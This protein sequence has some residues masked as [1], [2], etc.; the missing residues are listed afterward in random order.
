MI[1]THCHL[2]DL[3]ALCPYEQVL[4]R[5]QRAGVSSLISVGVAPARWPGQKSVALRARQEGF[6]VGLAY[7]IHPWWAHEVDVAA[8]LAAL[9]A[10]LVHEACD[11]L[12]VGEIGLDFAPNRPPIA[13]QMA[14]FEGQTALARAQDLPVILHERKSAD[15]LLRVIRRTQGLR[16]VVHGFV[17][18]QQQAKAFIAQGF[19]LGVGAAMTHPRAVRLRAMLAALPIE[20]LL[21]ESDAPNQSGALHQGAPNEP[22]FIGEQLAVLADVRGEEPLALG[23]QLD[24]NAVA[25]FG[26][27]LTQ[28]INDCPS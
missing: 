3:I 21:L 1:D 9:S 10:W 5:A 6:S 27:G 22:A 4:M 17:G 19:Y 8:G 11:T 2:D 7:G 14:L 20:H 16:G 28:A 13:Q 25:L 18:S 24:A 23:R 15:Q 12:A 26:R